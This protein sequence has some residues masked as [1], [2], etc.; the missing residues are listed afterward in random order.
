MSLTPVFDEEAAAGPEH[1]DPALVA[2]YDRKAGVDAGDDI[3]DLRAA[4]LGSDSTLVDLGAG[5]GAFALAAAS[6]CRRV[7]AVDISPAMVDL[8]E[9]RISELGISNVEC[10]RAGFLTYEHA[11]APADVIYTRNALHHLPDFWKAIALRRM[12][13]VLR[14]GGI[15]RLRDLV[16]A[17]GPDDAESAIGR[18]LDDASSARGQDGW[19]RDEL[20]T[21]LRREHS[22]F[23]WLLEPMIERAGLRI[24]R[25]EHGAFGIYADY[26]CRRD[27]P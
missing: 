16:F 17:F 18:W 9:T 15:L 19:T 20:E 24:D 7:I 23:T 4:G 21:H 1:L 6:R 11:G 3:E 8:M 25:A 27:H 5:T 22:T 10:V 14:P 12:A 26:T 13:D 2:G